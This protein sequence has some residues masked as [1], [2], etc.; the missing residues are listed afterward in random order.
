MPGLRLTQTQA[1]ALLGLP[2][3]ATGWVLER[4]AKDSFLARSPGGLYMRRQGEL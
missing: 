3:P 2:E 1:G 4:L